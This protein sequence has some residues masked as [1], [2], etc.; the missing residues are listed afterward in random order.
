MIFMYI[1]Q[2][3]DFA[4]AFC[5]NRTNIAHRLQT[6]L[7]VSM[8]HIIINLY[9]PESTQYYTI[10]RLELLHQDLLSHIFYSI[11]DI[12]AFILLTFMTPL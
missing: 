9:N 4:P 1:I 6:Q 3:S 8:Q 7:Y 10:L 2:M 5:T 12:F 11:L